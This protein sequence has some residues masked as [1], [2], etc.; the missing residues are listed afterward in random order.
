MNEGPHKHKMLE[1]V[2]EKVILWKIDNE[3]GKFERIYGVGYDIITFKKCKCG[4]KEPI[5]IEREVMS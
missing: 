2:T 5:K 1:T 3:K 4:F